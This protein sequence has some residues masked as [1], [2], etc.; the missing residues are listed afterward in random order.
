ME[1]ENDD[2]YVPTN[3]QLTQ[4]NEFQLKVMIL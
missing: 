1:D 4:S 2:E 3:N